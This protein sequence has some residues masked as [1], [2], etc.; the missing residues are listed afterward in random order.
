MS[1]YSILK[2]GL[3]GEGSEKMWCTTKILSDYIDEYVPEKQREILMNKIYYSSFGGHFDKEFA[4]KTVEKFYYQGK[5]GKD[6]VVNGIGTQTHK[7]T[8]GG[9]IHWAGI[10]TVPFST[11]WKEYTASGTFS[12]EQQDGNYIAFNLNDFHEANTY[13]FDNISVQIIINLGKR[14]AL[15]MYVSR[16]EGTG[17]IT[18]VDS[19]NINNIGHWNFL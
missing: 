15:S 2:E 5:D 9:Y 3:R 4:D 12:K 14:S 11:E 17:R 18:S 6:V 16:T 19:L 10:G 7:D 13:Y 8:P 1:I